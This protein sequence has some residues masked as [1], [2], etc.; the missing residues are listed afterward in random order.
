MTLPKGV[1]RMI[2]G[3]PIG[4]DSH[5]TRKAQVREAHNV[6]LKEVL[7]VNALEEIP[8]IQFWRVERSGPKT[9]H[10]DALVITTLLANYEVGRIFI[11]SCSL[12]DILFGE[13]YDQMQLGDIPLVVVNTSLYGF[14]CEV[15][16]PRGMISLPLTL[17]TGPVRKTYLLKFLVVDISSAY[18]VI[19]GRPTLARKSRGGAPKQGRKRSR[20]GREAKDGRETPVKVQ[21]TEKLLAIELI[22]R[23][24]EKT[25][26][27]AS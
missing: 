13:F 2:A 3:G 23:N 4:R 19:Q 5:H 20:V 21:P 22:P 25:A 11:N 26:R 12:A 8:R 16:H 9:S 14:A 15:V 27:M 24:L 18:N 17:G 6:T 7:D 1:I 10:Y